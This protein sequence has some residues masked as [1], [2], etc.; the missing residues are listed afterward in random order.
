[1]NKKAI[2]MPMFSFFVLLILT[3]GYYQLII[4][5]SQDKYKLIG[6][7]QAEIIKSYDK[8]EE[9]LFNAENAVKYASYK[10]IDD[11][12]KTSV[13]LEKCNNLWKFNSDCEPNLEK[14]FLELFKSDLQD[15][16]YNAK[17]IKIQDNS[18]IVIL[19]NFNYQKELSKFKLEYNLPVKIKQELAIDLNKLNK[20]K[21]KIKKC[22]QD[23]KDL[24]TCTDEKTKVE[25]DIITFTIENNKDILIYTDKLETKK[26]IFVFKINNKDNGIRAEVF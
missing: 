20:L 25:G 5:E 3:Y 22:A 11:F 13:V 7:N 14:T 1:M 23:G 21:E 2:F 9:Y 24:N 15:Y 4:N 6:L 8:G 17:E 16:G 18:I 10:S 26:P 19:D 12:S